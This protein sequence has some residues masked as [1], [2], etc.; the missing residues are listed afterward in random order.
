[1][2][3]ICLSVQH[4]KKYFTIGT[5]LLGR[6]TQYLKAVDDVSFDIPQGTT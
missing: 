2:S 3:E 1:M 4:L 5:D 6:P